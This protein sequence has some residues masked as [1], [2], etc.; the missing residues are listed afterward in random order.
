MFIIERLIS[1]LVFTS[2]LFVCMFFLSKIKKNY[3]KIV[4][5]IYLI[6]LGLFASFFKPNVL[7]L[8][9][10]YD[11]CL[12]SYCQY[13]WYRLKDF[14]EYSP[15]PIWHLYSWTIYHFTHNVNFLQTISCLWCFGNVFYIINDIIK[16][17]NITSL[18]RALLLF[19]IMAVGTFYMEAISGIRSM[20]SFSICCWCIYREMVQEKK[21]FFHIPLYVFAALM[22]QVGTVIFVGRLISLVPLQKSYFRKILLSLLV[23]PLIVFAVRQGNFFLISS[24]DL[25]HKYAS[26]TREYH[27]VQ[28]TIIGIVELIQVFYILLCYRLYGDKKLH[29]LWS[30]SLVLTV[31]SAGAI[32]I[33]YAI[34]RRYTV[35]CSLLVLPLIGALLVLPNRTT[36][37]HF[38]FLLFLQSMLIFALSYSIGDMRFYQF[39]MW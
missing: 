16:R 28:E 17:E 34:F 20:L 18:Y 19:S 8:S 5:F 33:S 27:M 6:L 36:R 25:A 21:L 10:L 4:L 1:L 12:R 9:R 29:N 7:D 38:A 13:P 31:V 30:F 37:N 22:H 32:P 23:I 26:N 14:L 39:L 11:V 3:C 2:T 15:V 35:M 24:F